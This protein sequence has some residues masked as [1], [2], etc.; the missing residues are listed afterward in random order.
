MINLLQ[1][2]RQRVRARRLAAFHE[3]Y[4]ATQA[5]YNWTAATCPLCF[6][7]ATSPDANFCAHCGRSL[8]LPL[9]AETSSAAQPQEQT[10]DPLI[11]T[12]RPFLGFVREQHKDIGPMTEQHRAVRL[13]AP[14]KGEWK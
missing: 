12:E 5:A 10:T 11:V 4:E 13:V 3:M 8:S 9:L 14:G 1:S 6:T 7:P 2:L